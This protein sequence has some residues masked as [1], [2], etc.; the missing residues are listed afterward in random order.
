MI[1]NARC[2]L[3]ILLDLAEYLTKR[4]YKNNCRY[5]YGDKSRRKRRVKHRD[6]KCCLEY[7]G[8][9]YNL[10][11]FKYLNFDETIL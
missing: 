6:C 1:D 11:I 5:R 3:S 9:T 8:M 2:M 7:I 10:L 4:T